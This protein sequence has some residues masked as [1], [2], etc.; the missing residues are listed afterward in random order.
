MKEGFEN[1][2]IQNPL[3]GQHESRR[4]EEEKRTR[5]SEPFGIFNYDYYCR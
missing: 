3:E 2:C 5:T 4:K 1:I